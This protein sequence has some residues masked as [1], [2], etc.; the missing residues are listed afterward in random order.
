MLAGAEE[1]K[2]AIQ[3]FGQINTIRT[4]G[5]FCTRNCTGDYICSSI[6]NT[7]FTFGCPTY[8]LFK[9]C[10]LL[11]VIPKKNETFARK[12]YIELAAPHNKKR[13]SVLDF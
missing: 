7:Y 13:L 9:R 6:V 10:C 5:T 8:I 1:L 2:L 4:L 11:V 12:I 3:S